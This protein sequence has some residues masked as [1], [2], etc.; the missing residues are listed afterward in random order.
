M[1]RRNTD[2]VKVLPARVPSPFI[3]TVVCP[4]VE[5][6]PASPDPS[7]VVQAATATKD[8]AT[9]IGLFD[10]SVFRAIDHGCF[11]GPVPRAAAQLEG[12]S[13]SRDGF[14]VFWITAQVLEIIFVLRLR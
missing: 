1:K 5:G 14:I 10:P 2:L 8:F 12:T 3:T 7:V 6:G 13:R 11:V 9:G 4:L